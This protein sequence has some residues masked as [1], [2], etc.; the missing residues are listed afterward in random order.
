MKVILKQ[1]VKGQ[2]RS[3]ELINVSDGYARNFLLPKGLAM[4]A[5]ASNVNTMKLKQDADANRR[6][7]DFEGAKRI[8]ERL[9]SIEVVLTAKAGSNGKLFGSITSKD[10]V[11]ALK[12]QFKIEIDKKR[13]SLHEGIKTIGTTEVD[14]KV[15]PE[16]SAKLKVV[17][18][19]AQE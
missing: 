18:K 9:S 14:V 17:V 3:G 11:D 15:F 1:D 16:V 4:E 10:V 7:K 13:L 8:A 12:K 19:Q 2:G 5:T 6:A